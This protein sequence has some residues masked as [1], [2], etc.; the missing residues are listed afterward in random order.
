MVRP[1][2]KQGNGLPL[3]FTWA[4]FSRQSQQVL[5]QSTTFVSH[6]TSETL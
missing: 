4:W 1:Y 2:K 5:E 3:C 6:D